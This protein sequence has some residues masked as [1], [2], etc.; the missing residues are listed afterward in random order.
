MRRQ[1]WRLSTGV[2]GYG[3][4][5]QMLRRSWTELVAGG[6]V[7]CARG[8]GCFESEVV[9]GVRVGGLIRPWEPWD[10]WGTTT[11][12]GRAIRGPEHRRCNRATASRRVRRVSRAL[13]SAVAVAAQPGDEAVELAAGAGLILDPW[14]AD[15]LRDCVT[16]AAR[17]ESG[18][19]SRSG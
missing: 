4:P 18:S 14:Q 6:V 5:H 3:A 16:A 10:L 1:R 13:V 7:R 2:R 9:G 11:M 19:T 15:V 8:A 12:I 17:T